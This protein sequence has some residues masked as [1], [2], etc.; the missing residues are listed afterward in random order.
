MSARRAGS[1]LPISAELTLGL[2]V[3]SGLRGPEW[4]HAKGRGSSDGGRLL[5]VRSRSDPSFHCFSSL[6]HLD[7][8]R[9]EAGIRAR[10]SD[11]VSEASA[12][13]LGNHGVK[14]RRS[15]GVVAAA[16]HDAHHGAWPGPRPPVE[17]HAELTRRLPTSGPILPKRLLDR[18]AAQS[19]PSLSLWAGSSTLPRLALD[20]VAQSDRT[21][22]PLRARV[23]LPQGCRGLASCICQRHNSFA[24]VAS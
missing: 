17:E 15:F 19:H 22:L 1:C 5:S 23:W 12:E 21:N 16:S 4:C 7:E 8:I 14:D 18:T 24:D 11:V 6:L 20:D 2:S 3:V 9:T 10:G 13:Q